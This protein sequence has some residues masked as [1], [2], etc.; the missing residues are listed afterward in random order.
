[1]RF[2]K[3][4][5][6]GGVRFNLS[7][8]GIG[9]SIGTK[10]LRA[11]FSPSKG[12]YYSYNLPGTGLYN[13]KYNSKSNSTSDNNISNDILIR[14][15]SYFNNKDI[16]V[17]LKNNSNNMSCTGCFWS[18]ITFILLFACFPIGILSCIL[19]I[20]LYFTKLNKYK[21]TIEYKGYHLYKIFLDDI[22]NGHYEIAKSNLQEI[23]NLFP[24][25]IDLKKDYTECCLLCNDYETALSNLE[26]YGDN[27][28]DYIKIMEIS[29]KIGQYEKVIA[30]GQKLSDNIR[31]Y[32]HIITLMGAGYYK[33]KKYDLAL[34]ILLQ[35]PSR[36]RKIDSAI[37]KY[38]YFLRSNKAI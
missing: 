27:P 19:Q 37:A 11:G 30:Y 20:I 31:S 35:G 10:G 32:T 9:A 6:V 14:N 17:Y 8:S 7:K 5:K 13:V 34:E 2:R 1:M 23:I 26:K 38:R 33:L 22:G 21:K 28:V 29:Y 25:K 16:P 15:S 12:N 18:F 3:S 24:D 4:V 36:K